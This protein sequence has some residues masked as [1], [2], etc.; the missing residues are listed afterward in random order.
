[1]DKQDEIFTVESFAKRFSGIT[2]LGR[3]GRIPHQ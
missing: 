1:M 2:K 3:Y